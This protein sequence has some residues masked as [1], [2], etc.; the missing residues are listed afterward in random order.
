[1][2]DFLSTK[3]LEMFKKLMEKIHRGT[4]GGMEN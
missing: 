3:R 1:M 4:F 2:Y